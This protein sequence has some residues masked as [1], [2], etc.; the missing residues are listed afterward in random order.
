MP[1]HY[2]IINPKEYEFP[3]PKATV[4]YASSIGPKKQTTKEKVM[5][6][7][8]KGSKYVHENIEDVKEARIHP[9]RYG[10]SFDEMFSLTPRSEFIDV[11]NVKRKKKGKAK[12]QKTKEHRAKDPIDHIMGF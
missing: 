4:Q 11:I 7:L 2:T 10:K 1:E 6:A 12:K 8:R 3:T 5:G 9:N